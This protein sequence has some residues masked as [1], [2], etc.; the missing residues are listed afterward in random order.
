MGN[1]C[2]KECTSPGSKTSAS[3]DPSGTGAS[4]LDLTCEFETHS[5]NEESTGESS[6]F[7]FVYSV[8]EVYHRRM[9]QTSLR[10]GEAQRIG[11]VDGTEFRDEAPV[12]MIETIV[13]DEDID[14][15]EAWD[16]GVLS[17]NGN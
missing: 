11:D 4:G 10:K 14:T 2:R 13:V 12:A 16:V 3:G 6:D 7:V 15:E 17:V 9:T 5:S 8:N 1:N